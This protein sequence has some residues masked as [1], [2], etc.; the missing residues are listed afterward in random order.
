M[1]DNTH[2]L[3]SLLQQAIRACPQ[4]FTLSEAR[5][6]LNAAL[7]KV[8][9]VERKREKRHV[10]EQEQYK[11]QWGVG[12]TSLNVRETLQY[13]DTMIA[14]EQK[15]IQEIAERRKQQRPEEEGGTEASALLG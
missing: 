13:I 11:Q 1:K 5:F 6:H 12:S 3:K 2:R 4:D 8:E 14:D 15:K 9:Q 7:N 10:A